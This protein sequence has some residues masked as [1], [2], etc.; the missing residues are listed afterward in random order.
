MNQQEDRGGDGDE[1]KSPKVPEPT[2]TLQLGRGRGRG[3]PIK[4]LLNVTENHCDL[5]SYS[6]KWRNWKI[7]P[8]YDSS[9]SDSGSLPRPESSS[10]SIPPPTPSTYSTLLTKFLERKQEPLQQ[11]LFPVSHF[12]PKFTEVVKPSNRLE[13]L[14]TSKVTVLDVLDEGHI[15]VSF[16]DKDSVE[17][18]TCLLEFMSRFYST[19]VG[20]DFKIPIS[21]LEAGDVVATMVH[22]ID[23]GTVSRRV[24]IVEAFKT[25]ADDSKAYV[26]DIDD[27]NYSYIKSAFVLHPAFHKHPSQVCK[28]KIKN[29]Q[30][31]CPKDAFDEFFEDKEKFCDTIDEASHRVL[32]SMIGQNLYVSNL[33]ASATD[34]NELFKEFTGELDFE[35][36][37]NLHQRFVEEICRFDFT[38]KTPEVNSMA[39][40]V[41][42]HVFPNGDINMC[43][44]SSLFKAIERVTNGNKIRQLAKNV[45]KQQQE[46]FMQLIKSGECSL[47]LMWDDETKKIVRAKVKSFYIG[48]LKVCF[49][50]LGREELKDKSSLICPL[51]GNPALP[52]IL[53]AIPG[54]AVKLHL[55]G[56]DQVRRDKDVFSKLIGVEVEFK[57]CLSKGLS[58][59]ELEDEL[60]DKVKTKLTLN[61]ILK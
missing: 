35:V 52:A 40:G 61:E 19:V 10:E 1:S 51:T 34:S 49:I 22:M 25:S 33:S 21:L 48:K 15:M 30:D 4:T 43:T 31:M 50:D 41:I 54:Q 60:E 38:P 44:N 5:E 36:N 55:A 12:F 29:L 27:L 45:T 57:V 32:T 2:F 11:N 28:L 37:W 7:D 8:K 9:E 6:Q 46:G 13:T 23:G 17:R 58:C 20:V 56:V 59:K 39:K 14:K 3:R 26:V 16:Q 18:F 47:F 24:K 53:S 42:A